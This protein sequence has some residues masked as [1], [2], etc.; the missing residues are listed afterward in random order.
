MAAPF[1]LFD[2]RLARARAYRMQPGAFLTGLLAE[3]LAERLQALT[4]MPRT[5]GLLGLLH[6]T[7]Q[8]AL[9]AATLVPLTIDAD[10]RLQL[11]QSVD[12]IVD[13]GRLMLAD[14][15]PGVLAQIRAVLPANGG[16]FSVGFGGGSL[17]ALRQALLAAE[18]QL[19]GGAAPRLH[20]QL[21]AEA[22]LQLLQR[23]GFTTPV[24][25]REGLTVTYN[26]LE[27]LAADL[28]AAGLSNQL[29]Q[30]ARTIPPQALFALAER[31]W[32]DSDPDQRLQAK[33]EIVA[34]TGW[35]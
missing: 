15:L 6:P 32:R 30:Q 20:P 23:A 8:A 10:E 14:D 27:S 26:S 11:S 2:P 19:T 4:V 22:G 5:V 33:F 17:A 21:T 34:L 16:F 13:C 31:L 1:P 18:T 28:R 12:V 35:A 3:A 25:D 24:A 7:L 29:A 9:P